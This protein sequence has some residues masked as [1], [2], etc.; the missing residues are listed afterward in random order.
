[1][2]N[3]Y[4]N[5]KIKEKIGICLGILFKNDLFLLISD[6]NE[7]SISH[8]LAEYL[9]KDFPDW[10]VDCEYNR[11]ELGVK[12]LENI[13]DCSMQKESDRISPDIIIHH[14]NS[15]HNLLVIEMKKNTFDN[16]DIE[17]LKLFTDTQG[18]YKYR[19]GLFIKFNKDKYPTLKWYI[20]GDESDL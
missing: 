14:R 17:K 4:S 3:Y 15:N 9:Q 7:R 6:A 1:M 11:K 8:K 5:T 2:I 16:C 19:F 20:D 18:L 10:N 12:E 13:K